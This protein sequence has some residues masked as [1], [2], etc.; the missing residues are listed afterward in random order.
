M[1]RFKYAAW[2][3]PLIDIESG[4]AIC[5]LPDWK[6]E[7]KMY[8]MS[9]ERHPPGWLGKAEHFM[10]MITVIFASPLAKRPFT[11]NPNS[12]RI[13]REY[14]KYDFLG[15]AGSASS[16]KTETMAIIAL[17]EFLADPANTAVLITSTTIPEARM[18]CWGRLE[19]HWQNCCEYFDALG[20]SIG[21]APGE[22][23]PPGSLISSSAMIRYQL[24]DRKETDRGIKLVPGK[25]SEVKEGIGRLKG[26]KA[27]KMRFLADE[28]SD[29]SHKLLEAAEANLFVGNDDFKM[30]GGYNPNSHFDPGG[31]FSEPI[32]G[33]SSI[34][35]LSSDGWK[36]KRGYC[37][38]FDGEASPN[39][40]ARH[41]I[42]DGLLTCE[43][44]EELK[45]NLGDNSPGYM[46]M[47]RG[48]WSETG[49]KDGIYSEA[50]VI[51]Y[52]GMKKVEVWEGSK[53]VVGGFDPSFVHG[54]DRAALV[55]GVTGRGLCV[56]KFKQCVEV[57][58]IVYLDDNIDTK[59]DK[60]KQILQ[61]LKEVCIKEGLDP[62]NLA[63]DA[64][65]GGD[66]FVTLMNEDKFFTRKFIPLGFGEKA[67]EVVF[68]GK[69]G[70]EKFADRMSEL[71]YVGRPL[72]HGG[73]IKGLKPDIIRE[74]TLRLY[75]TQGGSKKRIKV[76]PKEIMKRRLNGRSPDCSDAFFLMLHVCRAKHGLRADGIPSKPQ[77][78][79]AGIDPSHP[80]G[81]MF[82]WGLKKKPSLHEPQF[83][84]ASAGWADEDSGMGGLGGF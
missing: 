49:N 21:M 2:W 82:N 76:E 69:A 68:Q 17:G 73:Q 29:L 35:V 34:D 83:V 32:D 42:W 56:D 1:A 55:I 15:I 28:L 38:R 52:L 80:M 13:V 58:K 43:K 20:Q 18:R 61:R 66:V 23:K 12:V 41:K 19:Y 39:V 48:C 30:I 78:K 24:G 64:T 62:V 50:E 27:K 14:F 36:T 6:I 77:Q 70:S 45:K 63:M 3:E 60:K 79:V 4:K 47:V 22:L 71:W 65:G 51:N 67:S 37:I 25:E 59:Q 8:L 31:V 75:E 16:S 53:T 84:S 5:P 33:W 81:D 74:M 44:V 46:S 72:L 40:V 11:W 54:G 10:R 57:T 9:K 7:A 26:F